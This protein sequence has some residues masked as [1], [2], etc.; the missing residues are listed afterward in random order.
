MIRVRG[1]MKDKSK[2]QNFI[3][4]PNYQHLNELLNI[5]LQAE[6]TLNRMLSPTAGNTDNLEKSQLVKLALLNG[7]YRESG[8][9]T[10]RSTV[11]PSIND[12]YQPFMNYFNSLDSVNNFNNFYS[13]SESSS[14]GNFAS[15]I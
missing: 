13:N 1:S 15:F 2:E 14:I 8:N 7:T 5:L 3:D 9:L 10:P 12:I 11:S 6:D 4:R